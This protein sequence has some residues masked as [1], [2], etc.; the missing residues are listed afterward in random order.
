MFE[1]TL[2]VPAGR[3]LDFAFQLDQADRFDVA[4]QKT[5]TLTPTHDSTVTIVPSLSRAAGSSLKTVL[6]TGVLALV[7]LG[8]FAGLSALVARQASRA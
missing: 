1:V 5:H 7:A 8:L 6:E 2:P 3:R 4:D